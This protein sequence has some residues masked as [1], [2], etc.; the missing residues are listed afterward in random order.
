MKNHPALILSLLLPLHFLFPLTTKAQDFSAEIELLNVDTQY[1]YF[2]YHSEKTAQQFRKLLDRT[3]EQRTVL[4]HF[5]ASHIQAEVVTTKARTLLSEKFGHAGQ[6]FLFP[7]SAAKT[8]SSVNYKTEQ[9]GN[10]G[11]SKSHQI[12]PKIP[13]GPRGMT[14]ETTDTSAGFSLLFKETI[15]ADDYELIVFFDNNE[16]TPNFKIKSG[17]FEFVVNDSI[18]AE[19]A[20]KNYIIIEISQDFEDLHLNI[21]P[22]EKEEQLFRFYGFSL[23]RKEKT[24]LMYQSLGVGASPFEAVLHMEKLKEQAEIL[25]PDIVILDYGTNNILYKNAVPDKI[26]QSVEEAVSIFREINPDIIIVLTST[27]D[28]F[29]KGRYIEAAVEFAQVMDSLAKVYDCMYWNFYDLSGGFAQIKNWESNGYAQKDYIHLT[30]SGYKLKGYLLCKSITNTYQHI[31]KNPTES[32]YSVPVKNYD[33]L[34]EKHKKTIKNKQTTFST[35]TGT[36]VV[37]SG[38]TLSEIGRKYGI[39]VN[40]LKRLNKLSSDLIKVGQVLKVITSKRIK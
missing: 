35:G 28:L 27:Q 9:T 6:G 32:I 37:K 40:N 16:L 1:A 20:G 38:D 24:G 10:W 2:Q 8:Y 30:H 21:L 29:Y 25:K 11:F 13:L 34:I 39:S 33:T 22:S 3:K 14:V 15:P 31:I 5:G 4:F 7:F 17:D 19:W 23:E 36:H 26:Y 12:P 18:L